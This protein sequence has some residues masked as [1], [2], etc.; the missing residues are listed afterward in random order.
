MPLGHKDYFELRTAEEEQ[1]AGERSALS[2][3]PKSRVCTSP[4][5]GPAPPPN[6]RKVFITAPLSQRV[7]SPSRC[8]CTDKPRE[9]PHL[10][11]A[12]PERAPSQIHSA[13]SPAPSPGLVVPA[14]VTVLC[15]ASGS[16]HHFGVSLSV[17]SSPLHIQRALFSY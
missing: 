5:R 7:E 9:Y 17:S 6:T 4:E 16:D 2:C 14:G 8:V 1:P 15:S 13:R 3:P 10:P 11:S 12:S